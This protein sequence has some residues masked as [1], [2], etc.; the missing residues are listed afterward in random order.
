MVNDIDNITENDNENI[1]SDQELDEIIKNIPSKDI[2]SNE[3][4]QE[5][6]D[7]LLKINK[8]CNAFQNQIVDETIPEENY[9]ANSG[10][11]MESYSY[12]FPKHNH[13]DNAKI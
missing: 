7:L 1:M 11:Y 12:E 6:L 2:K 5:K 8:E 4:Y 9:L 3:R 10:K 13:S